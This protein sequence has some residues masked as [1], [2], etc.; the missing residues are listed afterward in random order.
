MLRKPNVLGSELTRMTGPT[1][2]MRR[3]Y[4]AVYWC[5]L[6]ILTVFPETSLYAQ[7]LVQAIERKSSAQLALPFIETG[8]NNGVFS[9]F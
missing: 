3:D 7:A 8:K 9:L 4:I 5:Y 1:L 6:R 2:S